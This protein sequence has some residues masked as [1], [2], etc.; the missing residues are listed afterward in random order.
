M[1]IFYFF[2]LA[3]L[4]SSCTPFSSSYLRIIENNSSY[5]IWIIDTNSTSNCNADSLLISANGTSIVDGIF[6]RNSNVNNYRNCPII[7][8]EAVSA[9]ISNHDSLSL[10]LNLESTSSNWTYRVIQSGQSEECDCK[11]TITDADIN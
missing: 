3:F 2:G 6:D 11:L 8:F 7:C 1:K 10:D 4:I 5:D 9:R